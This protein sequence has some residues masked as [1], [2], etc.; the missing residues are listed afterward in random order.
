MLRELQNS[1]ERGLMEGIVS[2]VEFLMSLLLFIALGGYLIASRTKQ[3]AVFGE[4]LIGLSVGLSVPGLITY[5]DFVAGIA[6]L[7]AVILLFVIGPEFG[8]R[9]IFQIKYWN[10]ARFGDIRSLRLTRMI[11]CSDG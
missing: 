1:R 6:S 10:I 5:T 7:G 9:G 4:I 3:S 2:T 11:H 8:I